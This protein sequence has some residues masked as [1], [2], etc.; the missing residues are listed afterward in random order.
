M[1][2]RYLS[3]LGLS[4]KR[5]SSFKEAYFGVSCRLAGKSSGMNLS[6][7][8][9]FLSESHTPNSKARL[10]VMEW[11]SKVNSKKYIANVLIALW[12]SEEDNM[13]G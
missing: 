5:N 2:L 6:S 3:T 10:H 7:V 8:V 13:G 12:N 4:R 9:R 11:R 1:L